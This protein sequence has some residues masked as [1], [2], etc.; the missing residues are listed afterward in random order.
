MTEAAVPKS[1]LDPEQLDDI[2]LTLELEDADAVDRALLLYRQLVR[3]F[4]DWLKSVTGGEGG[5]LDNLVET[6]QGWLQESRAYKAGRHNYCLDDFGLVPEIIEEY[7][8]SYRAR[9]SDR[10]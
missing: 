5:W 1:R 10:F 7:F 2:V 8:E 4:W 6:L 3:D 9:F